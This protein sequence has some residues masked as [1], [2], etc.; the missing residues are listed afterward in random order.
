MVPYRSDQSE[1]PNGRESITELTSIRESD[2]EDA[3]L[4]PLIERED[5]E[6]DVKFQPADETSLTI[7][8]Q[9]FLPYI[10]AG[11]GMVGAGIVL[12]IVQVR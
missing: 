1:L 5:E 9:V 8:L 11:L 7:A 10:I 3:D 6:P 4:E 12:D 2:D